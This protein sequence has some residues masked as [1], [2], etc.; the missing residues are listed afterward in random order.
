MIELNNSMKKIRKF[1]IFILVLLVFITTPFYIGATQ[2]GE[3]QDFNI[4]SSYDL[5]ARSQVTA[6]LKKITPKLYFYIDD[7]WWNS[8]KSQEQLDIEEPLRKLGLEF[9][10]I[11]YP[12]LTST[13]GFEWK[14]GIDKDERIAILIHPMTEG[15][16]GY[17]NSG[18]EYPKLQ[19]P[20]S[21]E[22]EMLYLNANYIT[23]SLIKSFLAHEFI[24]LITFNQKEKIFGVSEEIWLNEA[25]ADYAPTLLGY[26]NIY[27]GSN[28]QNRA[29]VFLENPSDSLTEWQNKKAD[30][31]V[32]NL[33][34]QYL[35]D[36]YGVRIL[37]DSLKIPETGITSLNTILTQR[38]F[39]QDFSQVFTDWT[40][41]IFLNDCSVDR[42]YCYLN[43]N[44][45]NFRIAPL[46]NF[47]PFSG[48]S[49]LS[50]IDRTKN[51]SGN[52]YKFVGGWGTLK[53]EFSGDSE[54]LFSVPHLSQDLL[55]N[56]RVSFF[57]LDESQ[58]GEIFVSGFR[59]NIMSVTIIPSIQTKISGFGVSE[60]SFSFSWTT[61]VGKNNPEAEEKELIKKLLEQIEFLQKEIAKIQ[62]EIAAILAKKGSCQRF[63][64]NLY[65][66]MM[67]N[68]E[69][70]CLQEFLK[71]QGSEIYSEG[72]VTGNFLSLTKVAVIRFQEKYAQDILVP[73]ELE[74]GTGFVG[75]T[76]IAKINEILGQ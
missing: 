44:L 32:I 49:S 13:F 47:L 53:I 7:D 9:S 36:H 30:Y 1:E 20:T 62:A 27:E 76:T 4:D 75:R 16:G 66:G 52:W 48:E 2:K 56:W 3:S 10:D 73:W 29:N 22:K 11:I 60:P 43:E 8:L 38:G 57:E 12:S 68:V 15:V 67:N 69:V 59:T 18:D 54:N 23:S 25:R 55:G 41:T 5:T 21:N 34:T 26:N 17:F 64:N 14:P 42:K 31:G 50:V 70:R 58:K 19:V 74:S 35:V 45:E 51:W 72:L 65:F 63:E 24:H 28:L 6:T 61:S 71:S 37:I 40:I 39:E 33:F 46:T